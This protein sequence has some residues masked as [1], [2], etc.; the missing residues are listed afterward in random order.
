MY[1][2]VASDRNGGHEQKEGKTIDV[3]VLC[4]VNSYFV[5]CVT[6]ALDNI[7]KLATVSLQ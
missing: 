7:I 1:T 2:S 6:Q 5:S 3:I 4:T